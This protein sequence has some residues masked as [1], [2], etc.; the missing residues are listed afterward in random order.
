MAA[1]LPCIV[2]NHSG[3]KDRVDDNTGWRCD[4]WEDYKRVIQEILE[5]PLLLKI[6]GREA[7]LKAKKE[8]IPERW[9]EEILA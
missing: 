9:I 5:N 6:K 8:F 4:T 2:D 1:G 7:R 3:P